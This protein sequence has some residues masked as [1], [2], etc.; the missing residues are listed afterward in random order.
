MCGMW[1]HILYK[2]Y[3]ARG[4]VGFLNLSCFENTQGIRKDVDKPGHL[5]SLIMVI[6]DCLQ[7]ISPCTHTHAGIQRGYV[8]VNIEANLRKQK[9]AILY[10]YLNLSHVYITLNHVYDSRPCDV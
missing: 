2:N 4:G 3:N 5:S 7:W 1:E 9:V 10:L 8:R 6:T